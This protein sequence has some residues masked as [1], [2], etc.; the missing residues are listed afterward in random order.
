LPTSSGGNY[1]SDIDNIYAELE[2]LGEE[3]DNTL[4]EVDDMLAAWEDEQVIQE[5]EEEESEQSDETAKFTPTIT[6]NKDVSVIAFEPLYI[7]PWKIEE[8]DVYRI[9]VKGY[10]PL[11]ESG[12]FTTDITALQIYIT[13]TPGTGDKVYI[14]ED[15]TGLFTM[16]L[17][18]Y[19]WDTDVVTRGDDKYCRRIS[20]TS[21]PINLVASEEAPMDFFTMS[22]EF[23][24]AYK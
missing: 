14:D 21:Q 7:Q 1:D 22:L 5:E 2:N 23:E 12:E 10:N 20:C 8:E 9:N 17:P 13:F 4:A 24:L 19:E 6:S 15:N 18:Y 11:E 3:L 16:A